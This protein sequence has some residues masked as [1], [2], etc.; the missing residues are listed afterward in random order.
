VYGEDYPVKDVYEPEVLLKEI[1]AGRLLCVLIFDMDGTAAGYASMFRTAP[2]PRIWE[3][4]NMIVVPRYANTDISKHL[5][6]YYVNFIEQ[7]SSDAD[8]VFGEAVCSHYFTQITM[9]K[10][11]MV[12]C[13]IELDQLDGSSFKDGKS[14]KAGTARISCVLNFLEHKDLLQPE[15]VPV[16]YEDIIKRIARELRQRVFLQSKVSLPVNSATNL[17]ERYHA[18]ARTWKVAVHAVGGDWPAVVDDI[19]DKAQQR[20]VISLQVTLNMACPHI[21]EAVD[22]LLEKGFFFG[23]MAPRWFGTDGLIMQ[24][25]SM[26]ETEYGDIKLYTA[27]ARELLEFI[28]RDR[29]TIKRGKGA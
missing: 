20:Q 26:S 29:E 12:D 2:N 5:V 1:H 9:A 14:N 4:G 21:G 27:T 7:V 8:G 24:N 13:G 19:L 17:E 25:I 28:K 10:I 3:V 16:R 23:G 6:Q 15:Y 11:G 18:P 22:V